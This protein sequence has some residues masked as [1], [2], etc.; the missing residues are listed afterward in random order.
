MSPQATPTLQ[1]TQT[2]VAVAACFGTFLEWYDFLTFAALAVWFGPLFFPP[3][4]PTAALLASLATFGAGMIVRPLGAALFGSLGDR[5]GRRKVFMITIALMGGATLAV[6]LLPT[7]AQAG[8]WAPALLVSL[9]LVQG[10]SAGGEIGGSAVY[11]TEHAPVRNRGLFT[12][13]LQLMGPLGILASTLQIALLQQLLS[14]EDF[15]SWGWRVPFWVSLVL[16][17][18]SLKVRAALHETPIFHALQA[19]SALTQTPLRDCFRDRQTLARMGLLFLCISA[20]GGI[21]FFSAQVYSGVFLK[22]VAGFEGAHSSLLVAIGTAVLFPLTLLAGWLSDRIGR[23]KV[24]LTGLLLGACS[25]LPV[26]N[27]WLNSGPAQMPL[28]IGLMILMTLPLALVTGP[29]TALLAELFPARTR[30]SA[31]ALPHNLAAGWIGGLLPFVITLINEQIGN[32]LAG[33]WYPTLFLAVAFVVGLRY[34]P[35]TRGTD[36]SQ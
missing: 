34:L 7:Y 3:E 4:N 2:R 30:Y 6:G 17:L 25:I 31:A 33:L 10:L 32:P 12:S 27:G 16:L 19:R 20:G 26:F 36:L 28:A 29:Q 21:L 24:V 22:T 18:I 5:I 15:M 1:K 8:L 11:L 9:R 35:E 23:R 14:T 13:I